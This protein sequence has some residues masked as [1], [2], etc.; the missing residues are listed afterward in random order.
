[1]PSAPLLPCASGPEKRLCSRRAT[2]AHSTLV[3][4]APDAQAGQAVRA[5]QRIVRTGKEGS[6]HYRL[7]AAVTQA[8]RRG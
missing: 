1:M 6:E 3:L 7:L 2:A 4:A 5:R 8:R